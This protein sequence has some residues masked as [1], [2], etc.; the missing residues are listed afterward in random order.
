MNGE[1]ATATEGTV[2]R[3]D[4]CRSR[5]S[6][7]YD[8]SHADLVDR[9]RR[10]LRYSTVIDPRHLD[11]TKPLYKQRCGVV[12]TELVTAESETADAIG[13]MQGGRVS[14]LI[15]CKVSR[16]DFF[17]DRK[18]PFRIHPER[19][20]GRFR[21]YM[22][23]CGLVTVDELPDRWG[24][25]EVSGRSVRVLRIGDQFRERNQRAETAMIWSIARR[26]QSS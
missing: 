19:G 23:P 8:V 6:N 9:A 18:K 13:W 25:L 17:A 20:V 14:V 16:A 1:N 11:G 15:E 3:Q 21:F 26:A 2:E 24:L 5:S 7:C 12:A 22:T 10:W 4:D